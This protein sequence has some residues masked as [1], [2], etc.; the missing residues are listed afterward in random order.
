MF[1]KNHHVITICYS[2]VF[3]QVGVPPNHPVVMDDHVP[4]TISNHYKSLLTTI[5][6]HQP[7]SHRVQNLRSLVK[8][9]VTTGDP[10]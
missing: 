1:L 3:S 7:V 4:L 10:P 9:M 5:I 2:K 6:H 8:P